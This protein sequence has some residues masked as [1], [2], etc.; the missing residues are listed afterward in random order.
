MENRLR[1]LLVEDTP[2]DAKLIE[3]ELRKTGLALT[4]RRTET[5]EE[6]LRGI[7]ELEPDIILSD[8]KLQHFDGMSALRIA[9]DMAPAIPFIVVTGSTD[10]ETA[11]DC[12]KAGATDYIVKEHLRR[13][14][15]AVM[16]ALER[17]RIVE[18]KRRAEAALRES[19]ERFRRLAENAQDLIYRYRLKPSRGFEYVSPS[20][21]TITGYTPDEHYADPDL[22][23]KI[24]HPDDRHLLQT[25][26]DFSAPLLVRWFRKDGSLVWTERR[27]VPVFDDTG[28][29]V[30][31]EGIARDVTERVLAEERLRESEEKLRNIVDH[32][33]NLFYS[34]TP[35]H[36]ITYISPQSRVFLDCEPEEAM[37]RWTEYVTDN[38][39]NRIGFEL[40]E[41]AIKT[42][43]AQP[44]YEL[45]LRTKKGRTVW[46]EVHEAPVVRDGKTVTVVGSLTNITQRKRAEEEIRSNREWLSV[47]FDASRDGIAVEQD[48]KIVFCNRAFARLFGCERPDELMWKHISTVQSPKD[49]ERLLEFTRKRL[50]GEPTPSVYEFQGIRKDGSEVALEAS[51]SI[52]AISGQ[53]YIIGL[54][55]DISER[56]QAEEELR[57]MKDLLSAFVEHEPGAVFAFSLDGRMLLVNDEWEKTFGRSRDDVLG[58]RVAELFPPELADH[59]L[60]TNQRVVDAKSSITFEYALNTAKGMRHYEVTKF[61]LFG[62]T[63]EIEAVAGI[64]TDITERRQAEEALRASEER[65]RRLFDEDLTGNFVTKPD[66]T[67]IACNPAFADLFGFASV[68]DALH[69]NAAK[70]YTSQAERERFLELVKKNKKLEYHETEFRRLDGQTIYVVE[71]VVGRYDDEGN[72]VELHGYVFDDTKRRRAEE[73][74]RKLYRAVEHTDDVIFITD[75]DGTI[76]YVN[77]AFERVYGYKPEETIGRKPKLLKS[78]KMSAGFYEEFWKTILAGQSMRGELVN[79]T[80]DGSFATVESLVNPVVAPDGNL[81]GFIAVQKDITTR[82][83]TGEERKELEAHLFQAQKMDSLGRLAGGIAH[84]FNNILGIIVG[85][86]SLLPAIKDDEEKFGKAVEIIAQSVNRGAGLVRQI[87]AFARKSDIHVEPIEINAAVREIVEMLQETFPKTIV[88]ERKIE[89]SLPFIEGDRTQLHQTLL[90]LCVNARDAMPDGGTL[91]IAAKAVEGMKLR[92]KFA[93]ATEEQYVQLSVSDTGGGITEE[94]KSHIFEPFFTTKEKGKGTGLGLSV[95]FGVVQ[96]MKGFIDLES[97]PGQ[98]TTFHVYLPVPRESAETVP[99]AYAGD[100]TIPGGNETLL[101]VEDEESLLEMLK[102]YLEGRGYRILTATDGESAVA[103]FDQKKNEIALVLTDMGLPRMTGVNMFRRMKDI[104]AEVKVIMA[105]GQ[106]EYG[107]RSE[108]LKSGVRDFVQKPYRPDEIAR[109]LRTVLDTETS[110]AA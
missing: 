6:F 19:E 83:K 38:P 58:V 45:E 95:V 97:R 16:A 49:N 71:N 92:H 85:Y 33:T 94:V 41:R 75:P 3:R 5:K 91:R 37:V 11:V 9:L 46:V 84:D 44:P 99:G 93:Q 25:P 21:T 54:F 74:L 77:P 51:V 69:T 66:G 32:S 17:K 105:S 110:S 20:S 106:I 87:L 1:V 60:A 42:G 65:Y 48:E 22:G 76:T 53:H 90:N 12:M 52:A 79:K 26:P 31:I 70:L 39:A 8:F 40:T 30:A 88:V 34:H 18:D 103:L 23:F 36:V 107:M 47:V 24:T 82:K 80:K 35:E 102:N 59:Y 67:I 73:T 10:E 43:I 78:G 89:R 68:E 100:L 98:G 61:P 86:S 63:E 15:P 104:R 56:K 72:L 81:S 28:E 14:A 96:S 27:N 13:L 55:R 2:A 64:A 101:L 62:P 29:L 109:K 7:F 57:E 4:L 108:L 50:R